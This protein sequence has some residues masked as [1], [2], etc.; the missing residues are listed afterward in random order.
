MERGEQVVGSDDALGIGGDAR[1]DAAD[2]T[3]D[4]RGFRP[5]VTPILEVQVVDD[6]RDPVQGR[7]LDPAPGQQHFE[8]AAITA[9]S[10]FGLEH[11]ETHFASPP[12]CTGTGDEAETGLR[13]NAGRDQ[14]GAGQPIDADVGSGDPSLASACPQFWQVSQEI[15]GGRRLRGGP[16]NLDDSAFG[17]GST[18]GLPVIDGDQRLQSAAELGGLT[19]QGI[20]ILGADAIQCRLGLLGQG[21]VVS[22]TR[23]TEQPAHLVVGH[24]LD[25]GRTAHQGLTT[26]SADLLDTPLEILGC[27]GG[28]GQ[29]PAGVADHHRPHGLEAPPDPHPQRVLLGGKLAE[30]QEPLYGRIFHVM[31][32]THER[33]VRVNPVNSLA[34]VAPASVIASASAVR[35]RRRLTLAAGVR[36]IGAGM[37]GPL[38]GLHLAASDA[39]GGFLGVVVGTGLAGCAAAALV[40]TLGGN[41]WGR[42]T[43]CAVL[44]LLTAGGSLAVASSGSSWLILVAAFVGMLNG[45]GKDRGAIPVL[46]STMLPNTTD[47]HGRT[48]VFARYTAM[49]D[50]GHGIGALCAGLPSVLLLIPGVLPDQASA[51]SLGLAALPAL[52][53]IPLYLGLSPV[54]ELAG[55]AAPIP[56]SP[57][58]RRTITKLSALFSLDAIGG[59]FLTSAGMAYLFAEHFHA[60]AM[61]IAILFVAARILN[62]LS[63]LASAK[64]A[65][66][67]G[68]VNTMVFTHIPSSLLLMTVAFVPTFPIA[69][70]LFL[71]RE[72][73]VEM[74]VPTRQ[75]YV[76]AVVQAHERTAASGITALVRMAGW[77]A[78]AFAA[79]P[80]LAGMAVTTPLI[81]GASLKIIYD[82]ALWRACRH[83]R[84]PE[85]QGVATAQHS[86]K[87]QKAE[88]GSVH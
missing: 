79:G 39:P 63:H 51:W 88:S 3:G 65:K 32:I 23:G 64:L 1:G 40:V 52:V 54:V 47:D 80:M 84:P 76:M 12:R 83:V 75:S 58:G 62:A 5:Q 67:I 11:I 34:V 8:G 9:M 86:A 22:V 50:V 71:I 18:G 27:L 82:L 69:A 30:E 19:G 4:P 14:P 68:L 48:T 72:G 46:E 2:D 60:S 49:Q 17:Q 44:C 15:G 16:F 36:A 74:D 21:R 33:A 66:R 53:A 37:T 85:E 41:R 61:Q 56:V 43:T 31:T 45:M 70:I 10:E 35:D 7:V 78:G 55:N 77:S 81:A 24:A 25:Q 42:R 73:L 28:V 87:R 59:G 13:I 6:G 20:A 29:A 57:A 38:I 26:G